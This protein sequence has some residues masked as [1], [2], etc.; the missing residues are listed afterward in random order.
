MNPSTHQASD[1]NRIKL[2]PVTWNTDTEPAGLGRYMSHMGSSVYTYQQGPILQAYLQHKLG[3]TVQKDVVPSFITADPDFDP[4]NRPMPDDPPD[5]VNSQDDSSSQAQTIGGLEFGLES[6]SM[7]MGSMPTEPT[8]TTTSFELTPVGNYWQLPEEAR[9]LDALLYNVMRTGITGSKAVLL[10]CVSFPSYVQAMC[11]LYKHF[12]LSR[13][14]RKTEAFAAFDNF[15]FHG[16]VQQFQ[17]D[18]VN[19]YQEVLD[20]KCTIVDW[21]M[22]Q[23]MRAFRNN[24][25]IQ[26]KIAED[27]NSKVFND[28]TNL[29]DMVQS[30]CADISAVG[31]GRQKLIKNIQ[32]LS[33]YDPNKQCEYCGNKGHLITECRKKKAAESGGGGKGGSQKTPFKGECHTCGTLL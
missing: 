16:D 12:E 3:I 8:Q 6:L 17:I 32:K 27:I 5:G 28:H 13:T 19:L 1:L 9:K 31:D 30:Y 20:S 21:V 25:T 29:L 22:T 11:V 18:F 33:K 4:A 14:G 7:A 15:D 23:V 2:I 10:N 24:K 26:Y